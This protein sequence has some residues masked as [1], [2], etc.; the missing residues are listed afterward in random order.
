MKPVIL[1]MATAAIFAFSLSAVADNTP[2]SAAAPAHKA[3]LQHAAKM[4]KKHHHASAHV[5]TVQEAL[6]KSGAKL[7]VDGHWG[8]H[9]EHALRAFQK[10]HKLKVDGRLDKATKKALGIV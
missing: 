3:E 9:T 10:A 7:K 1:A 5:K 2:A 4:V 6:N 8:H